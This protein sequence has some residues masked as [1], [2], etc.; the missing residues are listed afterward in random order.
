MA[1]GWDLRDHIKQIQQIL[2]GDGSN[3]FLML[4]NYRV[5]TL[6]IT[7]SR[8]TEDYVNYGMNI[9]QDLVLVVI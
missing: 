7:E 2:W 6:T 8:I 4:L 9:F 5:N 3:Q 1:K